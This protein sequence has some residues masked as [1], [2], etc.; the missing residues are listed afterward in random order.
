MGSTELGDTCEIMFIQGIHFIQ[1]Y[2]ISAGLK[3]TVFYCQTTSSSLRLDK[4]NII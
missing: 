4:R 1:G 2:K 3:T